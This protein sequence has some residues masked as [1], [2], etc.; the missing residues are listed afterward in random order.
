MLLLLLPGEQA[1]HTQDEAQERCP[2]ILRFQ[3]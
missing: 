2:K 3:P 1:E